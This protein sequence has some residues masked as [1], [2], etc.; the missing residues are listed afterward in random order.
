MKGNL[1]LPF[2][3]I[4][5]SQFKNKKCPKRRCRVKVR[6]CWQNLD[7][8]LH[9]GWRTSPPNSLSLERGSG[10]KRAQEDRRC[11]CL[12]LYTVSST[13]FSG[14]L[15]TEV[16]PAKTVKKT[17]APKEKASPWVT[18][19]G[20][21]TLGLRCVD[22]VKSLWFPSQIWHCIYIAFANRLPWPARP[23]LCKSRKRRKRRFGI[24]TG[25]RI[26][27]SGWLLYSCSWWFQWMQK[28]QPISRSQHWSIYERLL[29]WR[30]SLS[31][32]RLITQSFFSLQLFPVCFNWHLRH[33]RTIL[34]WRNHHQKWR[35]VAAC[36]GSLFRSC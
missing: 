9:K 4:R 31:R 28:F 1:R 8:N 16:Q 14:V 36:G 19:V 11:R 20:K 21:R 6:Q 29:K 17:E 18:T 5:P 33:F 2:H 32:H 3:V 27:N 26:L 30:G 22:P 15:L 24:W 25:N 10:Q 13:S 23:N 7:P 34:K 35:W 12:N